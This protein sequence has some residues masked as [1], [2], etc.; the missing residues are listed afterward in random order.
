MA[1]KYLIL[2]ITKLIIV[3]S[4][5]SQT[6]MRNRNELV[7]GAG[8]TGVLGD[9]GGTHKVG[10]EAFS[11]RDWNFFSSRPV[12]SAGYRY[13][14]SQF[15]SVSANLYLG[16]ISANDALSDNPVRNNRNLHFRSPLAEFST[17]FEFIFY[18]QQEG[19]RYKL[20][21]V[22]GFRRLDLQGYLFTGAGIFAFNPQAKY[23]DGKWY[24]LHKYSTEGQGIVI[25]RPKYNRIQPSIPIGIG[26]KYGINR[27]WGIGAEFGLRKTFTDYL[28]DTSTTYFNNEVI[29]QYNLMNGNDGDIASYFADPSIVPGQSMAGQQRGNP[30]DNDSYVFVMVKVF[31]KIP[32]GGFASPKF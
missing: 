18:K 11:M 1:K 27:T 19:A 23:L 16:M 20:R 31:Y 14:V 26:V 25:S 6:W 9:L 28:D 15:A 32:R 22:Q 2:F 3:S 10:S 7:F 21:G 12:I 4:L 17:Q 29:R 8:I 5:H 13:R 24:N 30:V